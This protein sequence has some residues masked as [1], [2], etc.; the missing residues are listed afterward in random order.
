MALYK[1]YAFYTFTF[2]FQNYASHRAS[3]N[4]GPVRVDVLRGWQASM[5]D[6]LVTERHPTSSQ[7]PAAATTTSACLSADNHVLCCVSQCSGGFKGEGRGAAAYPYWPQI[8]FPTSRL[9]PYKMHIVRCPLFKISGSATVAVRV[10]RLN[11]SPTST[12]CSW[13]INNRLSN[14][15]S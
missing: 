8:F 14:V 5:Y 3:H 2:T 9:F 12:A 11:Q 4:R 6:H 10:D 1:C 7:S 13:R 15:T